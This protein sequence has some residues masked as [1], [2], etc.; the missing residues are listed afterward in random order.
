MGLISDSPNAKETFL[1]II[2]EQ[3]FRTEEDSEDY[4]S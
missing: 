1:V 4:V 3:P 2:N